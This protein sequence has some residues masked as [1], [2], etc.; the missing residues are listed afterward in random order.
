MDVSIIICT[1]NRA[2]HLEETLHS[3][4]ATRVPSEWKVELV[5][6]DNASTDET[7]SV[8][9]ACGPK[10]WTVRRILAP[11][12]GLSRARNRGVTAST[13]RVLLFTD[14]DVRIPDDWIVPMA[15]P[16]LR[17]K[18]DAVA[19]GVRLA[20]PLRRAW[21]TTAHTMLLADTTVLRESGAKR[22]IGANMAVSRAVF[23]FVP[24]FDPRLGAGPDA[25][26]FHEETLF[27]F[28]LQGAG[29]RLA[30]AL[31]V[32]VEHYPQADRLQYGA[33]TDT[34]AKQGR[35]DA[36][37]DY[38]WRHT[39]PT[40]AWSLAALAR[41]SVSLGTYRL[42]PPRRRAD[43][44][45]GIDP[46][47]MT[48]RRRIAYHREM[49]RLHGTPRRYDRLGRARRRTARPSNGRSPSETSP[50]PNEK[51]LQVA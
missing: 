48:V 3:L 51:P 19:G 4:D 7:A 8:V 31:D 36:Y 5:V 18:A 46:Q 15:S 38:H 21:M 11:Q 37:L 35:S 20:D 26:G 13:G 50:I 12:P 40:R 1:R 24:G 34:M 2:S 6:V 43:T 47:E 30:M 39:T 9:E 16:I 22:L 32:S 28:Q 42:W 41:W 49:L 23:D 25:L 45:E 29:G 44:A 33:F 14:D 17:G 10:G 27:S